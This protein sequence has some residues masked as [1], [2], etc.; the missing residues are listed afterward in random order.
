M[1]AAGLTEAEPHYELD[2]VPPNASGVP[3]RLSGPLG[4]DG[5]FRKGTPTAFGAP[6]AKGNWRNATTFVFDFQQVGLDEQRNAILSF[7]GDGVT[8]R[9]K[10]RDRHEITGFSESWSDWFKHPLHEMAALLKQVLVS[11]R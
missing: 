10:A 2:V 5:A 11:I 7:E 3:F 8:L 6:A 4:L 1:K 9:G